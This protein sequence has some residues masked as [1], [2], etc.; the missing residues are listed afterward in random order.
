MLL[1]FEKPIAELE[2]KLE[3]MKHLAGDSD[4]K[5]RDAIT[6]LEKKIKDLKK[7]TFDNLTG[8]QRV[9]ISRHPDRPYTLDYIYEIT[10]TSLNSMAIAQFR[11]TRRW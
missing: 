10:T 8:W 7:E 1:E 11:M 4:D 3:D 5:V 9:Q 6:A 2:A